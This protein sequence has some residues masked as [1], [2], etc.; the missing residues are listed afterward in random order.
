MTVAKA[1]THYEGQIVD[2]LTGE[3][4][5][6]AMMSF[7]KACEEYKQKFGEHSLDRVV[8]GNPLDRSTG[9]FE[10]QEKRLREAMKSNKPISQIDPEILRKVIF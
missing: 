5:Y 3:P 9:K 1:N 2:D 4:Y 6:D 7:S 10:G 8:L